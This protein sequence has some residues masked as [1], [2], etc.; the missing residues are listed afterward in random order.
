MRKGSAPESARSARFFGRAR[1]VGEPDA[2]ASG[3]FIFAERADGHLVERAPRR[4]HDAVIA[5][6]SDDMPRAVFEAVG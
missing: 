1:Q 2:A 4:D 3:A 5:G 6:L